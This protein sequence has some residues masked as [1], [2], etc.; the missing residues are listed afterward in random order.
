MK[1]TLKLILSSVLALFLLLILLPA[2]GV[3]QQADTEYQIQV[4][5]ELEIKSFYNPE[6]NE[7]VIVRPD[8]RISV[9][10]ANDIPAAGQTPAAL[11]KTLSDKY[12]AQFKQPEVS[13]ILR[14]FAGQRVYVGGKVKR[15]QIV[16]LVRRR[17]PRRD[18]A[19]AA[20]AR[21]GTVASSCSRGSMRAGRLVG[22]RSATRCHYIHEDRPGHTGIEA[23][24]PHFH[25]DRDLTVGGDNGAGF[26]TPSLVAEEQRPAPGRQL[27]G[28]F[29]PGNHSSGDRVAA[30]PQ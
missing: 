8:G 27:L 16:D 5:D 11:A 24:A 9:Q 18:R 10:L 15:A 2:N 23:L 3:C 22:G 12:A 30:R 19:E 6:L 13:I 17:Q 1:R 28:V 4:G 25:R 21:S 7:K 26:Q 29:S 14:S 20:A